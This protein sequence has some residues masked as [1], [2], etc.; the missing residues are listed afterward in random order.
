MD[1]ILDNCVCFRE[2]I[3]IGAKNN[4]NAIFIIN[5]KPPSPKVYRKSGESF[6]LLKYSSMTTKRKFGN[7]TMVN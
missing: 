6:F 2:L 1:W 3:I 7:I 5:I 4:E